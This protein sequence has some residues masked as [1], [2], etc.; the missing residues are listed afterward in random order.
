LVHN[1]YL[2]AKNKIDFGKNG[3]SKNFQS[4]L[5]SNGIDS[6]NSWYLPDINYN[7]RS[8]TINIYTYRNWHW[9]NTLA[10]GKEAL[11]AHLF[12]QKIISLIWLIG[13]FFCSDSPKN[14]VNNK[15]QNESS[16]SNSQ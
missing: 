1:C 12:I 10:T 5:L 3:Q 2:P 4:N 13:K 6:A 11:I 14:D 8:G 9:L 7:N 16:K 15:H